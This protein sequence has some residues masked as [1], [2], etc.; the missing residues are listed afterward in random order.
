MNLKHDLVITMCSTP[1][2]SFIF[3]ND[4]YLQNL[5]KYHLT[6]EVTFLRFPQQFSLKEITQYRP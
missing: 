4:Q 3:Y 2:I 5:P 1:F 6:I